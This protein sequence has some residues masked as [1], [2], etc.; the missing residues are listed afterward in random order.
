M[1]LGTPTHL[2]P[3]KWAGW[4]STAVQAGPKWGSLAGA[5]RRG[6]LCHRRQATPPKFRTW[7]SA[8]PMIC[9]AVPGSRDSAI[10][11]DVYHVPL[12]G[13]PEVFHVL[14]VQH[15]VVRV[16]WIPVYMDTKIAEGDWSL[17]NGHGLNWNRR[18]Q[19]GALKGVRI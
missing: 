13:E 9:G 7:P 10:V 6:F 8:C 12:C 2:Q 19:P 15:P 16:R 1:S 18:L 4:G 14:L 11:Q 5:S 3:G 17:H